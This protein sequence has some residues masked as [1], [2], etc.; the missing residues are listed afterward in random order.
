MASQQF[1]QA[2]A[3]LLAHLDKQ[4]KDIDAL[5]MAAVCYRY[6]KHY[7]QAAAT[8]SQ[9]IQLAPDHGRAHQEQGHLLMARQQPEQ[10]VQAFV[11]ACKNNPALIASWQAQVDLFTALG[12]PQAASQAQ[13]E[14]AQLQA[15]PKHLIAAKDL[16][17]QGKILKAENLCRKFL[18]SAPRHV[19]AMRLLADIGQRL[20]AMDEAEFLLESAVLFEPANAK[21]RTDYI[22]VLRKRQRFGK[23]LEEASTLLQQAPENPQFQS[24][25]AI[26][27][28]QTGDYDQALTYFDRV[29]AKLPNDPITLTSKGHALKTMG[30]YQQAVDAYN[31]AITTRPQHGEAYYSLANL[32]TYQFTEQEISRMLA[33]EGNPEHSLM[34]RAYLYFALG[35][36]YED[37][38][39]YRQSF[40]YYQL[41]NELKRNSSGYDA[42][43]M[44]EELMAQRDVCSTDFFA[45]HQGQ[46]HNAADPIFILGLPRSGSTM[47]EQILSSH[48]QVDGTLELPNILA[49]AQKL[50][51]Q[52]KGDD[53]KPYPQIL[54]DLTA[55]ELHSMGE[56]FI[57][58]TAIHRKGAPFFIDK[59]PNNFRHIGLIKLILPNA[60]IIDTRR[61]PMACC[62]SNY[63]QLFA[64]GQEFSYSLEDMAQY[65]KDYVALMA[66][67]D[68]VLPGQV[69]RMQYEEVVEDLEGQVRR[70][71][72]FCGL[73]FEA[74]CLSF[75][76]TKRSVRTASS[77]QVRQ[78]VYR[79]GLEQWQ[80]FS[81]DLE[82]LSNKLAEALAD[83]PSG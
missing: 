27:L 32:K 67:W 74:A 7:E 19:E 6:Q 57:K 33:Q 65:Y 8:L 30:R 14:L 49:M 38:K 53:S 63:K 29:L 13:A 36:A 79:S 60:K 62:F 73:P 83:Y 18:Q 47:L 72:D 40:K 71:L 26:E 10:A 78:P 50:R 17:A 5:Y 80:H 9:L 61:H 45:A 70:L 15:S 68:Q 59:M 48:S 55:D 12:K 44:T 66:H 1:D 46:G 77:E 51:R 37:N 58:D 31:T 43:K 4:P 52:G 16:L 2:L 20:G 82:P 24:I 64:E 41:G 34:E 54:E 42:D 76:E 25:Y 23:A 56:Q 35:K 81:A 21:V 22:Q 75:H 28:M 69:L 3:Q 39:D 11:R